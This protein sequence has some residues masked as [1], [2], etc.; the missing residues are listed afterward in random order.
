MEL[1][2]NKELQDPLN[3][4]TLPLFAEKL[5]ISHFSPTQF[6][7]PDSAWLFKYVVLTQEQRR[8]LLK[9]NSAMEAGKRVGDA[10]QRH[11]ADVIYKLN[12]LTK[13]VA[14]TT[15][16]KITL[17]NAIQEQIEI[18]KEYNPV[19][20]KDADKKIKYL[21]EVPE[22]VRNAFKGLTELAAASPVTCERQVS[23]TSNKLEG[24]ISSPSLPVVGR[25]DF[26][27]GQMRIGENPTSTGEHPGPDAFLPHKIVELKTKYSKLGKVKKDGSRSFIVSPTPASA[28][29]NHVVQCAVYAAHWNFKVPVYLLYATQGG[30][31]I[32]DSTNCKHLTVEGMKKNLQIMNRT[33]MRRE[34][35]LSQFQDQTRSEIIDHAIEMIDG[36]FDHPFAWNG[37]PVDLLQEAKELWKVN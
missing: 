21:E 1:H 17:D 6:A 4:K 35:I 13:K 16:E 8:M 3:E 36:N 10:L 14:E 31:Q 19:D 15:N 32:F 18:L 25:I 28:S 34:K 37:L 12:P 22:I 9:S 20:D 30:F 23:I 33:F 27:F 7:L 24:F 2:I 5:K 11:L 26:D 29:F